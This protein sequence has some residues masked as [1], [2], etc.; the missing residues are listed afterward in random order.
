MEVL[1][2]AQNKKIMNSGDVSVLGAVT[3]KFTRWKLRNEG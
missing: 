2:P 3:T 1:S